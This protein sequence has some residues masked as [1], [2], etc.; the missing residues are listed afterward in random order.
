MSR[1]VVMD[2]VAAAADQIVACNHQTL[3]TQP[4]RDERRRPGTALPRPKRKPRR[5]KS[6]RGLP[7]DEE[8]AKLAIAYLERQRK[9][10]PALVASGLLPEPQPDVVQQMVDDFKERHRSGNVN[11]ATVRP[12]SQ[13]GVPFGGSYSRYSCEN[14]SPNSITDQVASELDKA[15]DEKRFVPW[16]YVFADYSVT[17]RGAADLMDT[18]TP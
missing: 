6:D 7:P 8:L 17:G 16:Q 2:A 12:F 9:H 3:E 13:K 18:R 5:P 10:W 14:S 4:A 1:E 15:H 11:I